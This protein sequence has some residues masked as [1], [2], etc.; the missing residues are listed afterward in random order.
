MHKHYPPEHKVPQFNCIH[1]G[2]YS[3][4]YWGNF[5]IRVSNGGLSTHQSLEYCKCTHCGESSYWYDGKMIVP[6]NAP[7]PPPHADMPDN[8]VSEYNEA[9][10]VVSSSPR[11]ACALLR[12]AL[13]KLMVALGEKG[14]NINEDIGSLVAKGLPALVQQALDFCRVVGNNSV[15]PGELEI[16]DNPEIAHSLFDM[17]NFIVEDRIA[18]PRQ[19]S[20]LYAKLP[21]AARSA[22]ATRDTPRA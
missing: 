6:S 10:N 22:I 20:A 16:N 2:V 14:K 11:A 21:E 5:L 3:A 12:L 19:I 18:R 4:Q 1:C 7:V 15:H 17:I 8:C 13:Q 9:R